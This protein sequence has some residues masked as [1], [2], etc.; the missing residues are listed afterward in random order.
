[1]GTIRLNTSLVAFI[2]ILGMREQVKNIKTEEDLKSVYENLESLQMEFEKNTDGTHRVGHRISGKKVLAFSDCIVISLDFQ[3]PIIKTMGTFDSMLSQLNLIALSQAIFI[4]DKRV[5]LRGG[6][7]IGPWYSKRDI[8]ISPAL[9]KAYDLEREITYPVIAVTK[10][11]YN[12]FKK[13]PHRNWYAKDID[14]TKIFKKLKK[15][16]GRYT[17][18]LDYLW[19]GYAA[20]DG[21]YSEDDLQRYKTE[22][23][24]DKKQ[25]IL[26]NSYKMSQKTFLINHK[27]AVTQ[28]L[29]STYSKQ[30]ENIKD[31]YEWLKKYHNRF[32]AEIEPFF[33][34]CKI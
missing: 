31:K 4:C 29:Q 26:T 27:N 13:H 1:M 19:V 22:K 30:N 5:F 9:A 2:D 10:L 32:I 11:A 8:L 16:D 21:W 28:G 34:E 17:Y 24:D 23:K 14:P 18:F 20:S 3:A 33:K 25:E 15:R 7:D 12:F 6:V